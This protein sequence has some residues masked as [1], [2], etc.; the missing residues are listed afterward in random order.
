M[1]ALAEKE[2][3]IGVQPLRYFNAC[4]DLGP[5]KE[6]GWAFGSGILYFSS[7]TDKDIEDAAS[8]YLSVLPSYKGGR[9]TTQKDGSR[10]YRSDD[11][12]NGG[13]LQ[14]NYFPNDRSS[15]HYESGCR[16]SDGS[17]GDLNEYVLSSVEE[18]FP[19][20]V[21]YPAYD[22]D[23]KQPNTPPPPRGDSGQS[24]QSGQPAQSGDESG[25]DQ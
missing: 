13:E 8:Q 9:G 21:V 19:D 6:E 1:H 15:M 17:M 12:A 3:V 11:G 25:E 16:P 4:T 2:G 24:G 18:A 7:L 22:E 10:E 5:G 20:L 23:T 14:V